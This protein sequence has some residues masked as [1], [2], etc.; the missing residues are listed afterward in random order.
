[1]LRRDDREAVQSRDGPGCAANRFDCLFRISSPDHVWQ[2]EGLHFVLHE[3]PII[4]KVG[5]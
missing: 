5:Y 2:A 1:M 4:G 3:H